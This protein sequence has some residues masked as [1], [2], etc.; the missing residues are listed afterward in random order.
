[1]FTG[2]LEIKNDIRIFYKVYGST[3]S[4]QI[5]NAQPTLIFLHG[6]P[7]VVDH[8]LYEPYWSKFSGK[9]MMGSTLQVVFID[10]RG[11]GRSYYDKNDT[12]DYGDKS[13]WNLK[14]WGQ[15]V[16]TFFKAFNIQ[17]PILAGVS[18]G[19]VVAISCAVQFPKELGGLILSDT[20]ARF[21]LDEVIE[22]YARKVK[23][24]GGDDKEITKVCN[25]VKQMFTE[26][27]PETYAAYIRNCIPYNAAN[28]YSPDLIARCVK[29][30]EVAF[31]YNRN[32]LTRFNFLPEIGN[33]ECQVLILS[34]DQNPVHTLESATRTANSIQ[35]DKLNFHVFPGAGSPVYADKEKEVTSLI[36]QY[37]DKLSCSLIAETDSS[38][39]A[40]QTGSS[41]ASKLQ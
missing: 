15:D 37:F 32:E 33:V 24:K 36:N 20:D 29:N 7:G 28:P 38:Q 34:G 1:M 2:Y 12:R 26:T 6:G 14:Q 35:P 10:H 18:F 40:N 23:T 4:D 27:T 31:L 3:N 21:D 30:E 22:H 11:S 16:H 25:T 8:S 5:N 13:K 39:E 41:Y 19:G 9:K 17:K